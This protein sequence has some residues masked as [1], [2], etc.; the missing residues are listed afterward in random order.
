MI[1]DGRASLGGVCLHEGCI[2]S[3]TLLHA[4]ETIHLADRA[5]EFGLKY[6]PPE[7]DVG[8][9]RGWVDET[10]SK[11][12]GGLSTLA[13]QAGVELLRGHARFEDPKHVAIPGGAKDAGRLLDVLG[14]LPG[15]DHIAVVAAMGSTEDARFP[16]WSRADQSVEET[17]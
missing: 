13:R 8:K 14:A 17:R 9:L 2:P 4:A 12:T 16:L 15:F 5:A 3:K 1:V 10:V 6:P 7:I 11:L